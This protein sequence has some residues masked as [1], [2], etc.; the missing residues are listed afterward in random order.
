MSVSEEFRL[1]VLDQLS[2]AV[3]VRTRRMFGGLG[4]YSGE[5][6]FSVSCVAPGGTSMK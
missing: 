2:A 1:H 5:T 4:I 3:P 6:F